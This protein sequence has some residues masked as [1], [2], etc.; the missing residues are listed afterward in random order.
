MPPTAESRRPTC[1]GDSLEKAA[2]TRPIPKSAGAQM[3][4]LVKQ[5]KSSTKAVAQ[6]LRISQRTVERYVNKQ[7]KRPGRTSPRA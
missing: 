3:R 4:F 6:L 7:I 1:V 5:H 2:T